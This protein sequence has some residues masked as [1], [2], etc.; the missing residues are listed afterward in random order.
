M[1]NR[2]KIY[3]E[4]NF[5]V[6]KLE[7]GVKS[8]E[9]LYRLAKVFREDTDFPKVYYQLTDMRGCFFNFDISKLSSMA[10]LIE[11]Y[12]SLDNQKLGVYI[13]N[14]PVET[15]YVQLFFNSLKY[16]R[17]SCST[18]EKAHSLLKLPVSFAEF[19][20]MIDI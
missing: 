11:E 10:S 15:A 18:L 6:S 20:K 8:F 7:P 5:G 12:Q 4:F 14:K 19:N 1:S 2:Y 17:E 9:E 16:K 13:I 3:P